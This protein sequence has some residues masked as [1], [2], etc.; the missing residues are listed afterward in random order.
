[1]AV[2]GDD[3]ALLAKL[4]VFDIEGDGK[5]GSRSFDCVWR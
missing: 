4:G 2:N 1:M 3:A 5:R